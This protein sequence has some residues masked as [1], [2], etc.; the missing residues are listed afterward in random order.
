MTTTTAFTQ[1]GFTLLELL[2]V[3]VILAALVGMVTPYLAVNTDRDSLSKTSQALRFALQDMAD[4]SWIE[5]SNSVLSQD[6]ANHLDLWQRKEGKWHKLRTVYQIPSNILLTAKSD[7]EPL[8]KGLDALGFEKKGVVI[9]LSNGEYTPFKIKLT[10]N[11]SNMS[12]IGD[13]VNEIR[14]Q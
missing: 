12:L 11:D 9:F 8:R 4:Q 13:G 14:I 7:K 6:G 1:R 10:L 3:L 5:G 2:V